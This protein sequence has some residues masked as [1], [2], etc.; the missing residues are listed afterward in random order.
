MYIIHNDEEI[1]SYIKA[2]NNV[3]RVSFI[4]NTKFFSNIFESKN[5]R[6]NY[7]VFSAIITDVTANC[8]NTHILH[9]LSKPTIT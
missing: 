3:L 2:Y 6:N 5:G 9:R 8:A 7:R 4:F 1:Q